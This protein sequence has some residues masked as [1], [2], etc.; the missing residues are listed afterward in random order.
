LPFEHQF[1]YAAEVAI[2]SRLQQVTDLRQGV[3]DLIE[4]LEAGGI[5]Q[6][7]PH[8]RLDLWQYLQAVRVRL[9]LAEKALGGEASV[10]NQSG[11]SPSTTD[12]SPRIR[13]RRARARRR[14]WASGSDDSGGRRASR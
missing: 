14:S 13:A 7:E 5:A 3:T 1:D 2:I 8:E 9:A 11:P 6:L 10:G 12:I 4:T